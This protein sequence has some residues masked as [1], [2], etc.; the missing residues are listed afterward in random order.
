MNAASRLKTSHIT[1]KD[2]VSLLLVSYLSFAYPSSVLSGRGSYYSCRRLCVVNASLSHKLKLKSLQQSPRQPAD[3]MN[4][5]L[6]TFMLAGAATLANTFHW[7]ALVSLIMCTASCL[8]CVSCSQA[9]SFVCLVK[10][11][12]AAD[13]H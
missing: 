9:A 6:V 3:Q 8:S 4:L 13:L 5:W 7:V 10:V 1:G 11:S 12:L 2:N